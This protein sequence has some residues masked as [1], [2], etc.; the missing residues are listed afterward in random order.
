MQ[1]Q[2]NP[3]IAWQIIAMLLTLSILL[4]AITRPRRKPETRPFAIMM[5]G[6]TLWSIGNILQ[7]LS[8]DVRWQIFFN[9]IVYFGIFLVPTGWNIRG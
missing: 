7:W 9:P 2:S 8:P 5:F 3:F 6:A 4:Y 1:F